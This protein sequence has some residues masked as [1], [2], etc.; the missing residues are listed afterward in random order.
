MPSSVVLIKKND[1]VDCVRSFSPVSVQVTN[2]SG[3]EWSSPL[4]HY[5]LKY[6]FDHLY[7]NDEE[8]EKMDWPGNGSAPYKDQKNAWKLGG[9]LIQMCGQ[10]TDKY[11]DGESRVPL[12]SLNYEKF[13]RSAL[14]SDEVIKTL[15][16]NGYTV[17]QHE[18][19]PNT[20]NVSDGKHEFK[21]VQDDTLGPVLYEDTCT[22]TLY[23]D[24]F[25]ELQSQTIERNTDGPMQAKGL[26]GQNADWAKF[27]SPENCAYT[28][29]KF[30][31]DVASGRTTDIPSECYNVNPRSSQ[32][33]STSDYIN[34]DQKLL[35]DVKKMENYQE[36]VSDI[37]R[38]QKLIYEQGGTDNL[39]LAM[40]DPAD[41]YHDYGDSNDSDKLDFSGLDGKNMQQ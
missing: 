21:Y 14:S 11:P 24:T 8:N 34:S 7:F 23:S 5:D 25:E 38:R 29:N 18:E 10:V 4:K 6:N 36:V 2:R 13:G 17:K 20:Y 9:M 12:E 3:Y 22:S 31:Q 19:L 40:I 26:W 37:C 28:Q 30:Q 41:D 39:D 16:S 27:V 33:M 35:D 32:V 1:N 15:E